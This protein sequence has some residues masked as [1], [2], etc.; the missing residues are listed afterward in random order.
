[1]ILDEKHFYIGSSKDLKTRFNLWKYSIEIG[2]SKNRRVRDLTKTTKHIRFEVIELVES[3]NHRD[4]EGVYLQKYWGDP[5][6]LNYC[7]DPN[8]CKGIKWDG[9]RKPYIIVKTGGKRVSV[10]DK[11]G[12]WIKDF[13]YLADASEFT[14]VSKEAINNYL[15]GKSPGIRGF[16]FKL[17]TD[18]GYID[19]PAYVKKPYVFNGALLSEKARANARA[20]QL[21]ITTEE[22]RSFIPHCKKINVYKDDRL[23]VSLPSLNA[24]YEWLGI[25]KDRRLREI[26]TGKKG[27][28]CHGYSFKYA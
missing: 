14:A 13:D 19:P 12:K 8:N 25:K 1:M 9:I 18:D 5:L 27:K 28:T 16:T 24:T 4:R 15:K 2:K 26:L 20:A 21:K 6:M 3:G 11:D 10:F 7:I 23:I 22:R 17:N